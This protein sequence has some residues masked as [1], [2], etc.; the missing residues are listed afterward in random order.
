MN[1][2]VVADN[3][4]QRFPHH[5]AMADGSRQLTFM[6]LLERTNRLG[7]ALLGLGLRKGDRIASLQFNSMETIELDVAA[8]RFGFV[9]TLLNARGDLASHRHAINDCGAKVL[10]FGAEFSPQVAQLRASLNKVDI[11]IVVGDGESAISGCHLY[12]DLVGRAKPLRPAYEVNESDWHSIYY[13]SGSTGKPKGVVLSQRNWLV[14]VRNHLTDMFSRASSTDVVMHAAP[15]SHGSGAFVWAHLARGAKQQIIRRFD[16]EEVLDTIERQHVTTSFMAPTMVIKLMEA[17][18]ARPRDK[19]SLHSVAYGGG[20]MAVERLIE[21]LRRWGPVFAQLYGQWE[22]PQMFTLLSQAQHKEA[23]EQGDSVRLASAGTPITFVRVGV[24]DEKDNLLPSGAEGEIVTAGDHLMVGYLNRDADTDAIRHGI[25][26]RTGDIGRVDEQ[27]FVYLIDR[28]ND[29]IVTG[30]N[31]VYP[32]E[33]E[34]VMYGHPWV[35]EALA[36]GVPDDVWGEKIHAIVVPRERATFDSEQFL[37]WCRARLSK[38]KLPRSIELVEELA[39]SHY[40][41]ILRREIRDRYWQGRARK[42]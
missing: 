29:V 18:S 30:G 25:W 3:A 21:A 4:F 17:D 6:Q 9:R 2:G 36:V 15:L 16:A 24:M 26:Q 27:G 7:T 33:I 37:A 11:T 12:E 28:K 13:T 42:I 8:A 39:K 38:D 40:G 22:A 31:N 5:V 20:P 14:L 32:R 35:R 34:E 23:L 19:S 41:K 1:L 10:L